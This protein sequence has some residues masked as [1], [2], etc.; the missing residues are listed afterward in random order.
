MK[1]KAILIFAVVVISLFAA[2][3]PAQQRSHPVNQKGSYIPLPAGAPYGNMPELGIDN[4]IQKATFIFQGDRSGQD[5]ILTF[6]AYDIDDP[7]ELLIKLNGEEVGWLDDD[8]S[9]DS[10][11]ETIS[12]VL[13]GS[14]MVYKGLNKLEFS[15]VYNIHKRHCWGV[16]DIDVSKTLPSSGI[17]GSVEGAEPCLPEEVVMTFEGLEGEQFL[18][19]RGQGIG[20]QDGVEVWLNGIWYGTLKASPRSLWGEPETL[21]FPGS[22]IHPGEMNFVSFRQKGSRH[23]P[24]PWGMK[25]ISV[26]SQPPERHVPQPSPVPELEPVDLVQAPDIVELEVEPEI[27]RAASIAISSNPKGASVYLGTS[28]TSMG[29]FAGLTPLR[30]D[31]VQPGGHVLSVV[32]DGFWPVKRYL[33][34]DE[35]GFAAMGA[36]LIPFEGFDF[37][38]PLLLLPANQDIRDEDTYMAP[39]LG[40]VDLDGTLD[41]LCGNAK[42]TIR[43][44]RNESLMG[45]PILTEAE[46]IMLEGQTIDV[47]SYSAPA[48]VDWTGDGRNDLIV[49]N[50]QGRIVLFERDRQRST[51]RRGAQLS[52]EDQPIALKNC[53]FPL[54]VD[55][56]LD[57]Q[58]DL[59][60]GTGLGEIFVFLSRTTPEGRRLVK[61]PELL[62]EG[63]PIRFTLNLVPFDYADWTGDGYPDLLLAG[64]Y[65]QM[66]ILQGLSG[67]G[68]IAHFG[69]PR[70]L[71]SGGEEVFVG[72]YPCPVIL[73]WNADGLKDILVA[74]YIGEVSLILGRSGQKGLVPASAPDEPD[75]VRVDFD[76][77]TMKRFGM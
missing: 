62:S 73:D 71:G 28:V 37:Q 76:E 72:T 3:L 68:R 77:K 44:F 38:K 6:K 70:I 74:N 64:M 19:Y 63:Q 25:E 43:V 17:Y 5:S 18:V 66:F 34:L 23:Q 1:R 61:G 69:P 24:A 54:V 50:G 27:K 30:I 11:S 56:D 15:N 51:F 2:L 9:D 49:G 4:R 55:F 12:L 10:W 45:P 21:K 65:G 29:R 46:P 47:G 57:G 14:L 16:K 41:I 20:G 35:G 7:G 42:G 60:A 75:V 48:W 8:T 32:R 58:D 36:D 39:A 33:T 40:D 22:L 13:P 26:L 59:L 52:C 67:D 53:A 31:P